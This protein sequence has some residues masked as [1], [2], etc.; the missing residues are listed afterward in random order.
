MTDDHQE[1]D[2]GFNWVI[3]IYGAVLTPEGGQR[4]LDIPIEAEHLRNLPETHRFGIG[5]KCTRRNCHRGYSSVT[6]STP[7]RYFTQVYQCGALHFLGATV[8]QTGAYLAVRAASIVPGGTWSLSW[9][10]ARGHRMRSHVV[11][12]SQLRIPEPLS[13]MRYLPPWRS[14]SI[15]IPADSLPAVTAEPRDR[16]PSRRTQIRRCGR[17][18]NTPST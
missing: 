18:D 11:T 12:A 4:V 7:L 5:G 10:R 15:L 1:N 8:S 3:S 17:A 2:G 14:S 9:G 16:Y 6:Q 13:R